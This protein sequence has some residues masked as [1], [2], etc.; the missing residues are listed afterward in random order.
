MGCFRVKLVGTLR[1]QQTS[2]IGVIKE[3]ESSG[4]SWRNCVIPDHA[5][6][7]LSSYQSSGDSLD[8]WAF[9]AVQVVQ[10]RR[11]PGSKFQRHPLRS[12]TD[13]GLMMPGSS[14]AEPQMGARWEKAGSEKQKT[15]TWLL[16]LRWVRWAACFLFCRFYHTCWSSWCVWSSLRR[17]Q[18]T[19]CFC[20]FA[21]K[22]LRCCTSGD[23]PKRIWSRIQTQEFV[24]LLSTDEKHWEAVGEDWHGTGSA[25]GYGIRLLGLEASLARRWKLLS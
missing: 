11:S 1:P 13:L 22:W 25:E 17:R 5:V 9:T 2:C 7:V 15:T 4:L 23:P 12:C 19:G 16:C 10:R 18:C 14:R 3:L 24:L 20:Q 21:C 6:P 8:A